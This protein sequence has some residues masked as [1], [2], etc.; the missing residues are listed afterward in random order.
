MHHKCVSEHRASA[1]VHSNRV[2]VL[3]VATLTA[4]T[5]SASP[6]DKVLLNDISYMQQH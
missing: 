5:V 6:K 1:V 3:M 2:F 4:L